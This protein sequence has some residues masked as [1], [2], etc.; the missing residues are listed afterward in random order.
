MKSRRRVNSAVRRHRITDM[1]RAT[2]TLTSEPPTLVI[3]SEVVT[4]SPQITSALVALEN[5]LPEEH[6]SIW[7]GD[8]QAAA[9]Q[10]LKDWRPTAIVSVVS[11]DADGFC[12]CSTGTDANPFSVAAALAVVKR[13][14]G[15][16]ETDPIVVRVNGNAV[17]VHA[18]YSGNIWAVTTLSLTDGEQIVGREP[19]QRAC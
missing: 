5:E 19:N 6:I 10:A 16:D 13:S 18:H 1:T 12:D 15:W 4:S 8:N 3:P 11:N 9:S 2:V 14:W 17:P 7:P